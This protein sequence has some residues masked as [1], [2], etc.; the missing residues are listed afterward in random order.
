MVGG[1]CMAGACVAEGHGGG[2]GHGRGHVW[3]T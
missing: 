2:E 1:A 3:H